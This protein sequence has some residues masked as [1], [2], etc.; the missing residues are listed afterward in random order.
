VRGVKGTAILQQED[1]SAH[2]AVP[3]EEYLDTTNPVDERLEA[4]LIRC[5]LLEDQT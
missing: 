1:A 3:V 4:D 2:Y 5:G